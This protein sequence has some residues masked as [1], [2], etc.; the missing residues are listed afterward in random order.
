[1]LKFLAL[2][3]I[4][5]VIETTVL[6]FMMM[7]IGMMDIEDISLPAIAHAPRLTFILMV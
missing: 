4:L 7:E 1:M 3:I 5:F 2:M 6:T